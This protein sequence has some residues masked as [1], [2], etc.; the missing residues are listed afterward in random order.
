MR[1]IFLLYFIFF[2]NVIVA[3]DTKNNN[4]AYIDL[5]QD[6]NQIQKPKKI[7]KNE[8]KSKTLNND[9]SN[10]IKSVIIGELGTPSLGSIGIKT[11]VN[12]K[13]GLNLWNDFTAD[14]AIKLLNLLPKRSSSRVYQKILNDIYASTSEPPKGSKDEIVEFLNIKLSRLAYNGQDNHLLKIIDQLPDSEKWERWKKW[15][16]VYY[17]LKKNDTIA[18]QKVSNTRDKYNSIFWKKAHLLCLIFQKNF[19]EANFVFDVMASQNLLDDTFQALIDKFLNEKKIDDY[20]FKDKSVSPINLVLLDTTQYPINY[21]MIRDFDF[22]YKSLLLELIYLEPEARVILTDQMTLVKDITRETLIKTY[23]DI[24]YEKVDQNL[25]LQNIKSNPNG[26]NRAKAWLHAMK[27]SDNSEKAEFILKILNNENDHYNFMKTS[28][29]YLPLLKS[30]ESSSLSQSQV[31]TINYID[32]INN[33]KKYIEKPISKILLMNTEETL[34]FEFIAKHNAWNMI[35]YLNY[36]GLEIPKINW[37]KY[38]NKNLKAFQKSSDK[39]SLN[40]SYEE[41]VISNAIR[42]S[43]ENENYLKSFLL[44]GKLISNKKLETLN[45][46]TIKD[47]DIFLTDIDFI[48]LRNDLRQEFLYTKFFNSYKFYDEN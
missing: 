1:F 44:I 24:A 26:L 8:Q 32:S 2:S 25:Y 33:P 20:T 9:D 23:Q 12:K 27:I 5:T 45:L 15:Y 16:I 21:Q 28:N 11:N 29:L 35:N 40:V 3:E 7:N 31:K 43:I 38:Y 14:E 47:I 34:G 39:F 18:C 37:D 22:E 36:L 6:E 17:F 48:N 41:F 42:N 13:I 30:L 46:T 10:N 4:E 19:S